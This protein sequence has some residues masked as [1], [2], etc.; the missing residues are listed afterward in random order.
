MRDCT[1]QELDIFLK[2]EVLH[3]FYC[4]T[5]NSLADLSLGGFI[6]MNSMLLYICNIHNIIHMYLYYKAIVKAK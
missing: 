4:S 1:N 2:L 5:F 6:V 3:I